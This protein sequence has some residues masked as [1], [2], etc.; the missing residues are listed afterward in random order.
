MSM[1]KR[2]R[3]KESFWRRGI[4]QQAN[5]G[6]S[7]RGWCRQQ[8]LKEASFYWWRRELAQ[9]E[10]E[11]RAASFV[12]VHVTEQRAR[13]DD[14]RIEIVLPDGRRVGVHGPVDRQRLADVL[15]V[16]TSASVDPERGATG[17]FGPERRAC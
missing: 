13:D 9:R 6:M 17:S 2:D 10:A 5:S 16:L 4:R 15:A 11:R 8:G 3:K 12:P 14:P 7:V 1:G